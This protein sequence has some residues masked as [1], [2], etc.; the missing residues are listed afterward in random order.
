MTREEWHKVKSV[1]ATALELDDTDRQVYLDSACAGQ[2]SMRT[3]VESLLKC[4]E[5][6]DAFLAA[7]EEI[8]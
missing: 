6:D 4:H 3:E 7:I 2:T 1:L 8:L 5:E